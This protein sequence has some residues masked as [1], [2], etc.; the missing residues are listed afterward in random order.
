MKGDWSCSFVGK[1]EYMDTFNLK[2]LRFG[3]RVPSQKPRLAVY[4]EYKGFIFNIILKPF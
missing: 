4:R 3:K 2:R 1:R